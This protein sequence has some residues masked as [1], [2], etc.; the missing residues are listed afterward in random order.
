MYTYVP[1]HIYIYVCVCVC[2]IY[3]QGVPGGRD[4]SSGQ[5]SLC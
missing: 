1:V 5:C 4:K 2:I 3:I